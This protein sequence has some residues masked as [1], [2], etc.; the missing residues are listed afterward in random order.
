MLDENELVRVQSTG[1]TSLECCDCEIAAT[2]STVEDEGLMLEADNDF[3]DDYLDYVLGV[4]RSA[5]LCDELLDTFPQCLRASI[6]EE[7]MFL[8]EDEI[9]DQDEDEDERML[10]QGAL[11]RHIE[12]IDIDI[13]QE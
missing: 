1:A 3:C 5:E 8:G 11:E 4:A 13:F 2:E 10:S 9:L 6:G 12:D 7:E